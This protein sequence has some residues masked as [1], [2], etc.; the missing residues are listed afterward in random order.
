MNSNYFNHNAPI[1][2]NPEGGGGGQGVGIWHFYKKK[3]QRPLPRKKIPGQNSPPPGWN[4]F[5]EVFGLHKYIWRYN[6][7]V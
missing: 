4:C 1:N 2:V 3:C 5:P 7:K 6:L